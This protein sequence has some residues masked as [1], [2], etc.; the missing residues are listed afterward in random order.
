MCTRNPVALAYVRMNVRW[1]YKEWTFT[2][3]SH[4]SAS[5]FAREALKR[6]DVAAAWAES[7]TFRTFPDTA[8][9]LATLDSIIK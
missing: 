1:N 3:D 4:D 7:P 5:A 6:P 9:A 2:F 8:T